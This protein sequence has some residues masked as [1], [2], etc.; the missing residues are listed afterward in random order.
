MRQINADIYINM[1]DGVTALHKRLSDDHST[2]H[3]LKDLIVWREEEMICT[4]MLYK[5]INDKAPF[6]CLARGA[7]Q[8]TAET[9]YKLIFEQENKRA[10]LSFPM[11]LVTEMEE[12]KK[13]I[14]E[15]RSFVKKS[16]TCFDPADLEEAYLPSYAEKARKEGKDYIE[17][18]TVAGKTRLDLEQIKE[19]GRDINSQIY[20]RDFLLIDQADMIISFIPTHADGRACLSSGV[21]RELQHAHEA[22]KDVY[23]IWTAKQR[24]SV[25]V[26]QTATKVFDSI[27][28]LT[29][30]FTKKGFMK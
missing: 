10:Y 15:F 22:G 13:E 1:I 17:V 19:I 30:F 24:P 14:N 28:E 26:T 11:T 20:A 8:S 5:S 18:E 4:E 23:V 21:E 25:F 3:T 9:F 2:D 27:A 16:M 29:D 6:Y 12:V 7:E